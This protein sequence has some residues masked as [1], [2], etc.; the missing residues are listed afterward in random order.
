[1]RVCWIH[2]DL[3]PQT[4][5][6]ARPRHGQPAVH[7]RRHG[8]GRAVYDGPGAGGRADGFHGAGGCL[9]GGATHGRGALVGGLG[10]R[11]GPGDS[12]RPRRRVG[13]IATDAHDAA[14]RSRP[15][16]PGGIRAGDGGRSPADGRAVACWS[17]GFSARRVAAVVW[18]GGGFGRRQF[19][20]RGADHGR[21]LYGCGR[22]CP[23]DA[24][25]VRD[26]ISG[27]WV[28]RV[29]PPVRYGDCN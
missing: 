12:D 8:A 13:K 10:G 15:Q 4:G 27:G 23:I 21:L 16:V 28:R 3:A 9:D 11:S 26:C 25:A 7:P 2:G 22:G 6:T 24:G 17:G 29:A 18:H 20:A 14:F 5:G 19:G 1:M